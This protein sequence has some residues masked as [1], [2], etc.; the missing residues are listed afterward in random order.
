MLAEADAHSRQQVLKRE[1]DDA[2]LYTREVRR[3]MLCSAQES[4]NILVGTSLLV[5]YYVQK[6]HVIVGCPVHMFCLL[7]SNYSCVSC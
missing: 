6:F 5:Y 2:I 3:I 7:R 4:M 1:N